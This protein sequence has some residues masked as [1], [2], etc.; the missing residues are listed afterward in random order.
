MLL[1][2]RPKL[3]LAVSKVPTKAP[4]AAP[5]SPPNPVP[6]T[7]GGFFFCFCFALS[8][9]RCPFCKSNQLS[10]RTKERFINGI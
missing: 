5:A 8:S 10:V 3:L 4:T 6:F 2:A 1:F 9:P 7:D